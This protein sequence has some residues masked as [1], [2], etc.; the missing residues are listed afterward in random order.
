[1]RTKDCATVS[2]N[3]APMGA[4]G[5]L[6]LVLS[7]SML[8]AGPS[9]TAQGVGEATL[10]LTARVSGME[11][12]GGTIKAALFDIAAAFP[13]GE[14]LKTASLARDGK[15]PVSVVFSDLP[16]G[17]YAISAFHDANDNGTFDQGLF[18][19]PHERYGFSNNPSDG[20]SAPSFEEARISLS[21]DLTIEIVLVGPTSDD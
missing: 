5:L 9:W 11:Q 18:G 1:M 12:P 19:I 8:W 16:P 15:G 20:L 13:D 21:D 3:T 14:A 17:S 2:L 6:T 10:T 7:G 4:V